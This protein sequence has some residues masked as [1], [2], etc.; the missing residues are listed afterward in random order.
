[1]KQGRFKT[2]MSVVQNV[3]TLLMVMVKEKFDKDFFSWYN[4]C[5]KFGKITSEFTF[6]ELYE[7]GN[8]HIILWS[9]TSKTEFSSEKPFLFLTSPIRK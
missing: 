5:L 7:A 9:V 4:F 1:M 8:C 6:T 2:Y 3:L